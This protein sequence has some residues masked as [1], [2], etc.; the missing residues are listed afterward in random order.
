[1]AK[2]KIVAAKAADLRAVL[3]AAG[4][5]I[6][7]RSITPAGCCI[8]LVTSPGRMD[9]T[10]VGPD[11]QLRLRKSFDGAMA[12]ASLAIPYRRIDEILRSLPPEG[13]VNVSVDE[14]IP[15]RMTI[16]SGKSR[17]QIASV[18]LDGWMDM[19]E[20]KTT[21]EVRLPEKDLAKAIAAT[22]FSM[23]ENDIRNFLNGLLLEV[24][25]GTVNVV[26]TNGHR[27]TADC[28]K[29]A[30]GEATAIIPVASVDAL[31]SLL[32]P[33]SAASI[34]IQFGLNQCVLTVGDVEMRSKLI[35]G[36]F[37]DWRRVIPTHDQ[38]ISVPK[39]DFLAAVE[40]VLLAASV[41]TPG[42]KVVIENGSI[43][44]CASNEANDEA[45]TSIEITY[46]G[47]PVEFGINGGYLA[48]GIRAVSADDVCMS[49]GTNGSPIKLSDGNRSM[50]AH[51]C[52]P[53]RI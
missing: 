35:S 26:S 34:S 40:Q 7:A 49:F 10:G 25:S 22:R 18:D 14:S 4:R 11:C 32:N 6:P 33:E 5:V 27:L 23:A 41:K 39:R 13:I 36:Q 16:Q 17:F 37:P 24:G 9:V 3:A 31:A 2:I 12:D 28:I 43:M 52:M 38:Q 46:G 29:H 42:V 47:P 53:M 1:M 51:I 44:F 20:A 50:W 30:D 19:A 45:N 21:A 8:R 48:D 15:P